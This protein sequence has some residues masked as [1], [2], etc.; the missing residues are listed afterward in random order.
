MLV[1]KSRHAQGAPRERGGH[2]V[3]F[4][5]PEVGKTLRGDQF[6]PQGGAEKQVV[7]LARALARDS[8]RVAII[9]S[10]K[11]EELPAEVGGVT[12]GV[13]RPPTRGRGLTGKFIEIVRIWRSL[14]KLPSR[15]IVVRGATVDL[16]VIGVF[17]R[18]AR[19]RLVFASANVSDFQHH[20]IEPNRLYLLVY[21]LGVLLS[22]LIVV[23]TEEQAELCRTA[24][25]RRV[26][27]IRSI[28][29]LAPAEDEVPVAFLWVGR[30]VA[31]KRPL[32][33]IALARSLPLARFWM[34][35]TPI[36]HLAGDEMV[37]DAVFSQ[38]RSV[39]N[40]ELLTPRPHVE[41]Q[42]LMAR[43]VASVNTAAFEG[44]SNALLEGWSMGVPALVLSYD[45]GGVVTR[46]GL[47]AFAA[48]DADRFVESARELWRTRQ[49]RVNLSE[50]CRTYIATHHAPEIIAQQWAA[51]AVNG[52][53]PDRVRERR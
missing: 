19:R 38:A 14:A 50:R 37:I 25:R 49:D 53:T 7:M 52:R 33:Y 4:Y 13:R 41:L 44:M 28:S 22:R 11:A 15:C 3:V 36:P 16:G 10:G 46:H 32:E 17:A 45:P 42:R 26:R 43:A 35:G 29:Q 31:Y 27:V 34:V 39:P 20:R 47:G 5:A 30:L 18:L 9:V 6:F 21:R 8:Y 1:R 2:D 24:F 12:I 48:G 23:Q 40:L 51:L